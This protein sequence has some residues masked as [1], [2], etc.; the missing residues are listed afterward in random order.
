MYEDKLICFHILNGG[1]TNKSLNAKNKR[2]GIAVGAAD[3]IN[4]IR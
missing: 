3:T 1:T 2:L 4:E